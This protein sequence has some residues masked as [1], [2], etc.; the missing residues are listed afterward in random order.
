MTAYIIFK[1]NLTAADKVQIAGLVTKDKNGNK[2]AIRWSTTEH[3][4]GGEIPEEDCCTDC[5]AKNITINGEPGTGKTDFLMTPDLDDWKITAVSSVNP[6]TEVTAELI[7]IE[8]VDE[9]KNKGCTLDFRPI[10]RPIA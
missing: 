7:E 9:T 6:E 10:A 3:S 5:T 8:F 4:Y 1:H 2:L